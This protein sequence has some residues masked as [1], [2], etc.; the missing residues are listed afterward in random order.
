MNAS[1]R[2]QRGF[3][4]LEV[5]VAFMVAALLLTV[6]LS[7]FTT[8]MS[9]L[10]KTDGLS[11]AALVAQSRLEELG[12]SVPLEEGITEGQDESA[13]DY[14]WRINVAPL[15]WDFAEPLKAAGGIVYRVD[16]TVTWPGTKRRGS[17][18]LTSLRTVFPDEA[19]GQNGQG[20]NL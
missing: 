17:F 13:P 16:V 9:S 2:P 14:R 8:G 7:T 6:I 11:V 10:A 19:A 12:V 3:T 15:A 1:F 5:L 20:G 18:T 4:I